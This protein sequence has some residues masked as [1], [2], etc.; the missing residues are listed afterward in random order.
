MYQKPTRFFST[1]GSDYSVLLTGFEPF[2]GHDTNISQVVVSKMTGFHTLTCP[3]TGSSLHVHLETDVLPVDSKGAQRTAER[4]HKG[5]RWDAILHVGLCDS[6]EIPRIERLAQDKLNMRLPDNAGRHVLDG[7]LD[8]AGDRGCWVD[9]SVWKAERFPTPYTVSVDAGAYLC[10]E[11]YHATL[12]ALCEVDESTP[13]PAPSLFLH[14]PSEKHLLLSDAEAFVRACLAHLLRP[15]PGEPVHVVAAALG[16]PDGYLITRRRLEEH[17]G[18]CWEFPG[19][20]CDAGERWNEA[21]VREIREELDLEVNPLHPLG[22]WYRSRGSEAFVIHL[23]SC[24]DGGLVEPSLSVHDAYT[25]A[26]APIEGPLSWAGRDG[27]MN[28]FL[29]Q[30]VK[31]MSPT[32]HHRSSNAHR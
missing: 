24:I 14:L 9:P 19:G 4:I 13:L 27:E 5:E 16:R 11:T 8:D 28:A 1:M 18:G 12:K 22:S 21:M 25:W 17:D 32:H 23:V 29:Q 30:H 3:W 31:P 7:T 15:Y 6:C 20:K 26:S 2:G 10:N